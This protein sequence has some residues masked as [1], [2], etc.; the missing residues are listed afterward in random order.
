MKTY[1][2]SCSEFDLLTSFKNE[3]IIILN[4]N[5]KYEINDKVIFIIDNKL[6]GLSKI[7]GDSKIEFIHIME[8]GNRPA[9]L[10][11]LR[12]N[13]IEN[14]GLDYEKNLF[15][16]PFLENDNSKYFLDIFNIN[17]NDLSFYITEIDYFLEKVTTLE[18][19]K[20]IK[21]IEDRK[22][23]FLKDEFVKIEGSEHTKSQLHLK[24]I[25]KIVECDTWIA[26]ND[27]SK[28]HNGN[29]LLE[30]TLREIPNFHI[31]EETKKRI[32]LIDTI[33]F[34]DGLP[35]CAFETET[36]TSVYSGILRMADLLTV[37]PSINLKLYIV[38]PLERKDKVIREM[39]RPVFKAAGI[40]DY[41]FYVPLENL[42]VLL[43]KIKG[44]N[45]HVK[46]SI[47]DS[48]AISPKNYDFS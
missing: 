1:F 44:L 45:G 22:I 38:A 14:F 21:F 18:K 19:E 30:D 13:I 11:D 6:A 47:I 2:L 25:G 16:Q 12:N 15:S 26:F 20:E 46:H 41:C 28:Q 23:N 40:T 17:H 33:W 24:E 35:V 36:T 34:K 9:I 8:P 31:D 32:S 7:S 4:K 27:H 42:E 48:I 43:Q 3:E 39:N 29:F 10:G 5:N 37:I